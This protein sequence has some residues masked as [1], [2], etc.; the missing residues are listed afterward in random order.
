MP[1]CAACTGYS[2]LACCCLYGG[3]GSMG[4]THLQQL[5]NIRPSFNY[6]W[7]SHCCCPCCAIAQEA[8]EIRYRAGVLRDVLVLPPP[9]MM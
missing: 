9:M 8:R 4:R 5:Y 7:M 1:C 3:A 2:C 6:D